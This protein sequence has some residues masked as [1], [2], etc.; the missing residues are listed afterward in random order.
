MPQKTNLKHSKPVEPQEV[1]AK[2]APDKEPVQSAASMIQR[3]SL[4]ATAATSDE[5]RLQRK[6]EIMG[7]VR[8]ELAEVADLTNQSGEVSAQAMEISARAGAELFGAMSERL[9]TSEELT[10]TLGDMF[11]YEVKKDGSPSKTPKG[12]GAAIRK[13]VVRLTQ[14]ADYVNGG[15]TTRFFDKLP[16][17]DVEDIV[18]LV[19]NGDRSI[20]TAYEDLGKI[21]RDNQSRVEFAFDPKKI[22]GL[23]E[24]LS[25]DGAADVIAQSNDLRQAYG[26]LW[27]TLTAIGNG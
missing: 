11:G 18:N 27:D 23:V 25:K 26:A 24:S 7:R 21:K 8:Q 9:I 4:F 3:P 20:W 10:A 12:Q 14:A 17:E 19:K 15:E 2:A 1:E 16:E 6:A 13:R 22:A 5:N